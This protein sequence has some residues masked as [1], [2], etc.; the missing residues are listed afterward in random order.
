MAVT[1]DYISLVGCDAL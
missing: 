1:E